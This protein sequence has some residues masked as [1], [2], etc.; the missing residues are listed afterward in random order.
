MADQNMKNTTQFEGEAAGTK[1]KLQ[2]KNLSF[3]QKK[4]IFTMLLLHS[5]DGKLNSRKV[6]GDI[7]L[8]HGCSVDVVQRI[9]QEGKRIDASN[10]VDLNGFIKR[11]KSKRNTGMQGKRTCAFQRESYQSNP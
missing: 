3:E 5:T 8:K 10:P 11:L 6:C 7:A 2:Q 4:S 1:R 9:W